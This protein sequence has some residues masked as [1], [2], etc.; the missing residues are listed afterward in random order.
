MNLTPCSNT[1]WTPTSIPG[2]STPTLKFAEQRLYAYAVIDCA[3]LPANVHQAINDCAVASVA[4]AGGVGAITA[5]PG[6]ALAAFKTTFL[7]CF[8]AKF[9]T[10]AINDVHLDT[11]AVC[12]W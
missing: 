10:I 8:S 5:N 12:M 6:A 7:A 3:D 9:A 4:A 11:Q 2:I 1:E